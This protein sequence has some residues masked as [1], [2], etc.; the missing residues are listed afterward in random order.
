M[1]SQGAVLFMTTHTLPL[2]LRAVKNPSPGH[3]ATHFPSFPEIMGSHDSTHGPYGHNFSSPEIMGSQ[4]SVTGPYCL[5]RHTLLPRDHGLSILRQ[6]CVL[7]IATHSPPLRDHVRSW[8][9]NTPLM[10]RNVYDHVFSSPEIMGSHDSITWV[11]WP[12]FLLSRDH[13]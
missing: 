11:I 5:W 4:D 2:R 7:F 9:V 10:G 8:E 3:L 6:W 1:G 12:Q 13:G